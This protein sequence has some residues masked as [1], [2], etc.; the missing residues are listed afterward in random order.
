VLLTNLIYDVAQMA[1]PVDRVDAEAVRRPVRW[2]LRLVRR[3]MLVLGP[4]STLF[5]M[6]T[7]AVLLLLFHAG[8]TSFRTGWFIESLVTQILMIFAVRTR[9]HLLASR[10]HPAVTLL[11][12]GAVVVAVG[13]PFSPVA[14]Q[15]GFAPPSGPFLVF[16]P[17]VVCG[18][19]VV[20]ELVKHRLYAL[21]PADRGDATG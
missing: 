15:L 1:L 17:L 12:A 19:L 8:E 21:M 7:F 16:L 9:R 2:D 6:I 11:T 4:V 3:F 13:L 20:T 10:A 18:F 5:D 14:G